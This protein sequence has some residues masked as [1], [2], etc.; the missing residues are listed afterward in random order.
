MLNNIFIIFIII[1]L[2]LICKKNIEMFYIEK[3]SY[4]ETSSKINFSHRNDEYIYPK[5]YKNLITQYEIDYI[6][7][8]TIN[9]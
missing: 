9:N 3:D 4:Q 6:L 8:F 2:L 5:I 1:L 7:N